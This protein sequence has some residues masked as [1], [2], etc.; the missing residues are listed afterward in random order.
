MIA[1]C[2]TVEAAE[3]GLEFDSNEIVYGEIRKNQ[4]YNGYL[5]IK[6]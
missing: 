4:A 3:D 2:C 5:F 6:I 1:E